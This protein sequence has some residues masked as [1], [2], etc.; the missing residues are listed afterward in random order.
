MDLAGEGR[1]G[2]VEKRTGLQANSDLKGK[3][4]DGMLRGG[5]QVRWCTGG[6]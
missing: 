6:Q 1:W 3:M 5:R 4:V 2:Q